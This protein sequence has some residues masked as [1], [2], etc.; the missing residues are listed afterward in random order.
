[1]SKSVTSEVS[2][3]GMASAST[4]TLSDLEFELNAS[5]S[6]LYDQI[7]SERTHGFIAASVCIILQ[8][9]GTLFILIQVLSVVAIHNRQAGPQSGLD[10]VV[11]NELLFAFVV[12]VCALFTAFA[13]SSLLL[14]RK[15]STALKKTCTAIDIEMA[16]FAEEKSERQKASIL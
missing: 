3:N 11:S 1:M 13:A 7:D 10:F 5:K 8:T 15:Y 2:L 6:I 9:F 12:V 4:N 16:L 14:Y